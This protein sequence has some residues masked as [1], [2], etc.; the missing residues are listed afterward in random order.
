MQ[1]FHM[2]PGSKL[3]SLEV[4]E[5]DRWDVYAGREAYRIVLYKA[6]GTPV[7]LYFIAFGWGRVEEIWGVGRTPREAMA[8]AAEAAEFLEDAN[9]FLWALE[10]M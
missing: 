9:I 7:P 3:L 4:E 10:E 2:P 5:V 1:N 8:A 6:R